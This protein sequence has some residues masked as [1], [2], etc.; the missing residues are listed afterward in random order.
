M[1]ESLRGIGK[2]TI[3]RIG[4]LEFTLGAVRTTRSLDENTAPNSNVGRAVSSPAAFTGSDAITYS[5]SGKDAASFDLNA[6]TG[7]LTTKTGVSYDFEMRRTA[8]RS[9]SPPARAPSRP[10]WQS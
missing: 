5:L 1:I 4:L 7:Q 2:F 9:P 8:T 6:S 3:D 10:L